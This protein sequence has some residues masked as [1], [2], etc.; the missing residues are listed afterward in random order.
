MYGGALKNKA[1]LG[2]KAIHAQASD[3]QRQRHLFEGPGT[4]FGALARPRQLHASAVGSR[5]CP[6]LHMFR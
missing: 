1:V 3:L 4:L 5:K 6:V 2:L